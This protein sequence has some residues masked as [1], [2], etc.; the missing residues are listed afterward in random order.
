[1]L[2]DQ[3]PAAGA[4]QQCGDVLVE[5]IDSTIRIL[6]LNRAPDGVAAV[7]LPVD[8]VLPRGR[9]RVL[10]V[11]H[12][13]PCARIERIDHHLALGRSGDLDATVLQV[14]RGRRNL[15][16]ALAHVLGLRRKPGRLACVDGLLADGAQ[17]QEL[18]ASCVEVALQTDEELLG[19]LGQNLLHGGRDRSDDLDSLN[20]GF[21]HGTLSFSF[22]RLPGPSD[23]SSPRGPALRHRNGWRVC[24]LDQQRL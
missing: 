24:A 11:R 23:P 3:V 10:E 6:K 15:P 16:I 18:F 13:N 5:A 14:R 2:L 19:F 17:G 22:P 7:D 12:E 20:D 9:Q 4:Y 21:R 8:D 1:M